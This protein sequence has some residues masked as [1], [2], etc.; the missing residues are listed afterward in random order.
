MGIILDKTLDRRKTS[1]VN[2]IQARKRLLNEVTVY[3]DQEEQDEEKYMLVQLAEEGQV[4]AVK[5]YLQVC[6]KLF[7][8]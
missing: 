7:S 2:K 3:K 8:I 6:Q 1:R 5:V 4:E